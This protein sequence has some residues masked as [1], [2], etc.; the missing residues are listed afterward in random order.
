MIEGIKTKQLR[1]IP[2][3]RGYLMEILRDDDE[4][5]KGF[6]QCYVSA[7]YPGIVKAW[8]AHSRQYDTFSC[9]QG[10]VKV[11]LWDGREES[12]THGETNSF[13]I[14]EFNRLAIQI[15]PGVWHGWVCLGSGMSVVLNV[16]SEHYNYEEPDELRRPWDD[17][18]I[19]FD[20]HVRGG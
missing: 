10:N 14:G 20:W 15:P 13:V 6:G 7:T 9:V 2:D 1:L 5:F 8:H 11:G 17:P 16:P 19:G 3:D 18:E 4:M 12:P